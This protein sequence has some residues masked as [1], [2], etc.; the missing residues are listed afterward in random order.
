MSAVS[1]QL[2][3]VTVP[4]NLNTSAR[5]T[6]IMQASFKVSLKREIEE[7]HKEEV[8]ETLIGNIRALPW[9]RKITW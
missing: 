3:A 4:V 6:K 2:A 7:R 5:G 9:T 1:S 8:R